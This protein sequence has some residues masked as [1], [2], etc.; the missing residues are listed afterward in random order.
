MEIF[1]PIFTLAL[2]SGASSM[3]ILDVQ[4]I[5]ET[6]RNKFSTGLKSIANLNLPG[7]VCKNCFMS[8]TNFQN[9]NIKPSQPV[10]IRSYLPLKFTMLSLLRPRSY[11]AKIIK[12]VPYSTAA[13]MLKVYSPNV[14]FSS[15]CTTKYLYLD[16]SSAD[17]CVQILPYTFSSN[18]RPWNTEQ[19]LYLFPPTQMEASRCK[20]DQ[21][22]VTRHTLLNLWHSSHS[23]FDMRAEPK[24]TEQIRILM[25]TVDNKH[26]FMKIL[27]KESRTLLCKDYELENSL[28][29][30]T[31]IS[32][33]NQKQE[34]NL[35]LPGTVLTTQMETYEDINPRISSSNKISYFLRKQQNI[36][37]FHIYHGNGGLLRKGLLASPGPM[38][39]TYF[40]LKSTVELLFY[41][42]ITNAWASILHPNYFGDSKAA[43][44]RVGIT[45]RLVIDQYLASVDNSAK[46]STVHSL[47]QMRFI[48]CGETTD[49]RKSLG[50]LFAGYGRSVWICISLVMFVVLPG[51]WYL[52]EGLKL[53]RNISTLMKIVK[54]WLNFCSAAVRMLLEQSCP[55]P[56]KSLNS[57]ARQIVSSFTLISVIFLTSL[58]KENKIVG[59]IMPVKFKPFTNF[60]QLIH[61]NY[62][63]YTE[64]EE[65]RANLAEI[66]KHKIN[67]SSSAFK[68]NRSHPHKI[69]GYFYPNSSTVRAFSQLA[70][71]TR[72]LLSNA[73]Q[74]I[75]N[76]TGLAVETENHVRQAFNTDISIISLTPNIWNRVRELQRQNSIK[77]LTNC[78]K[79]AVLVYEPQVWE[80]EAILRKQGKIMVSVGTSAQLESRIGFYLFGWI[81]NFL[82]IRIRGL[83][84]SGILE[85]WN[86]F[87]TRY[88]VKL[89]FSMRTADSIKILGVSPKE[90]LNQPFTNIVLVLVVLLLG[91]AAAL[92]LA[93][94]EMLV[95]G[96]ENCSKML[97]V[98][99]CLKKYFTN[100]TCV[101]LSR[102]GSQNGF[103]KL[104]HGLKLY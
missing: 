9:T 51:F 2:V 28:N 1:I 102:L 67:V 79:T 65:G 53:Q 54:S 93:T 22:S 17:L 81:P 40:V 19:H 16:I 104:K 97:V 55:F 63:I 23:Q 10:V 33:Q 89:R 61:A 73:M 34:L 85:W 86:R 47:R 76:F 7:L 15:G 95:S 92:V 82:H 37:T 31:T 18:I 45:P 6:H 14:N 26:K 44:T 12:N 36:T 64:I 62:S 100:A 70:V 77:L 96:L 59:I 80:Y 75:V 5:P 13:Q 101:V 88:L 87:T 71:Q 57:N 68:F 21:Y 50:M 84:A 4:P 39:F 46:Y 52:S 69:M 43:K 58:Y 25:T 94:A 83:E 24:P 29:F 38:D 27:V 74:K 3:K 41:H 99:F 72:H 91:Y 49:S 78:N 35:I 11:A 8:L 103:H 32:A 98:L 20:P 66:R 30:V 90:Q 56:G 48:S 60:E 42:Q